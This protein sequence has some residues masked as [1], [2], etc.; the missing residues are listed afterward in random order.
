MTEP[1]FAYWKSYA[2]LNDLD[3]IVSATELPPV[4]VLTVSMNQ[5]RLPIG[6][7][8]GKPRGIQTPTRT[9]TRR[10]I[11]PLSRG[12]DGT[13]W[14]GTGVT[15]YAICTLYYRYIYIIFYTTREGEGCCVRW[16]VLHVVG[17]AAWGGWCHA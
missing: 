16:L 10:G 11:Y 1:Q 5:S 4:R 7:G 14:A 15:P 17:S 8:P 3:D 9:P 6:N 2:E 12:F 13:G